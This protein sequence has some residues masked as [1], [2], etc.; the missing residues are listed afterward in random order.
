MRIIV[1]EDEVTVSENISGVLIGEGHSVVGVADN[2]LA[3]I[4]MG[5]AGADL[6]LIDLR[7]KDGMTG[8]TIARRLGNL[9]GTPSVFVS[10]NLQH[11]RDEAQHSRV[12]GCL[13]KPFTD[14]DLVKTVAIAEA[15]SAGK[16]PPSPPARLELYGHFVA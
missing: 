6:A 13:A 8:G 10:A 4:R 7:L 15:I 12:I 5:S 14:D 2:G 9:Y 1:V 3:A 11:C 16:R